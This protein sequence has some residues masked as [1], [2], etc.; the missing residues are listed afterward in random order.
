MD[1]K[2]EILPPPQTKR[3]KLVSKVWVIFTK[4]K[5]A[6]RTEWEKCEHCGKKY[7]ASIKKGTSSLLKHKDR[8]PI[9]KSGNGDKPADDQVSDDAVT[10][11]LSKNN[12]FDR[13]QSC[14]II[15][16]MII[17][18]RYPCSMVAEEF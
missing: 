12:V 13:Q 6:D 5:D 15:A 4:F 11:L 3:R 18:H 14:M 16:T 2:V 7:V 17:E 9:L 8:Y 10:P 1:S